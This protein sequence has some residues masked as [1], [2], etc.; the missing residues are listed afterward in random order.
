MSKKKYIK[1]GKIKRFESS[2]MALLKSKS[3]YEEIF[4]KVGCLK[5]CQKLDGYNINISYRSAL[6]YDKKASKIGGLNIPNT[7]KD[8]SLVTGIPEEGENW[9]KNT[10]LDL[11]EWR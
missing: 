8:I 9:F 6:D 11:D 2:D 3:W 5:F 1:G 10:S 7:A 4:R